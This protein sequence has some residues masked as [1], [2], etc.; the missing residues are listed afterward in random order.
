MSRTS[1]VKI[2]WGQ[3]NFGAVLA[4]VDSKNPRLRTEQAS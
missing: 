1:K 3:I 4:V 2:K